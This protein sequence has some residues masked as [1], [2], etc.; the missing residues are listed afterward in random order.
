MTRRRLTALESLSPR[1][2]QVLSLT[3]AGHTVKTAA[4]ELGIAA[5]TVKDYRSNILL[6]LRAATMAHA[7][8]LAV[9]G[10]AA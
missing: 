1:E 3:A 9:R 4:V 8:A 6:K 2:R 10:G 5:E 7:T